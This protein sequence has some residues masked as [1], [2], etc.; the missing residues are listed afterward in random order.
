LVTRAHYHARRSQWKQAATDFEKVVH[1]HPTNHNAWYELAPALIESKDLEL[2]E[3]YRLEMSKRFA[4]TSHGKI[5]KACLLLP[6]DGEVLQL[7]VKIA[8]TES[9][10]GLG[11]PFYPYIQ[12]TRGLAEL[13]QGH[14]VTAKQWLDQSLAHGWDDGNLVAPAQALLSIVN[15]QLGRPEDARANLAKAVKKAQAGWPRSTSGDLG[16]SWN[17]WIMVQIFLREARTLIGDDARAR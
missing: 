5:T 10:V 14:Y 13:R 7:A 16:G 11:D 3:R 17:D 12:F 2:Y 9:V 15:H 4:H 1:L 6:A 8:E